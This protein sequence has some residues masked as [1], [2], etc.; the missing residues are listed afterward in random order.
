MV[1]TYFSRDQRDGVINCHL[2]SRAITNSGLNLIY[3]TW[4]FR[5]QITFHLAL[6]FNSKSRKK[7]LAKKVVKTMPT[8]V[9]TP[10][11]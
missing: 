1:C 9:V 5:G 8:I 7:V 6:T 4:D 2:F 10:L 3:G 11:P